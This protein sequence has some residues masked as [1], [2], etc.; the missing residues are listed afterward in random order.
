[1]TID[2]EKKF[3]FILFITRFSKYLL[4]RK[5]FSTRLVVVMSPKEVKISF[6]KGSVMGM[7]LN[8]I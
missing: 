8:Y 5:T 7:T 4:E 3:E 6:K 2:L 1:M